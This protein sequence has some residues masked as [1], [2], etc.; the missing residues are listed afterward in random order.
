MQLIALSSLA[1]IASVS[2]YSNVPV[3]YVSQANNR[4]NLSVQT[5]TRLWGL[6]GNSAS[7]ITYANLAFPA[8][9]MGEAAKATQIPSKSLKEGSDIATFAGGCFWGLELAFQRVPGVTQTAVGYTQGPVE[10]PDYGSVCSGSTGHTEAVQVYF[11]PSET[12]FE[13]LLDVF[14]TRVDP[15]T[16]NG[17]GN[18]FGSQYRTGVYVHSPEQMAAA[19]AR[20]DKVAGNLGKNF[21]GQP[22]K[23]ASELK[24]AEIF[25]PA[26]KYHQQYLSMGGRG[27]NPQSAEKGATDTIRCYG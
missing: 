19:Q 11:D 8:S 20:F 18:D 9:E 25:W 24:E 7:K 23:I 4:S 17:Q 12:S 26:E 5:R 15:T 14:F 1:L 21:L 27:G 22:K 13:K 16:V 6:F 10:M 3:K 2:A